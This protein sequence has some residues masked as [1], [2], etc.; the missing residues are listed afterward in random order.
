MS[1]PE[2]HTT[3]PSCNAHIPWSPACINCGEPLPELERETTQTEWINGSL[4]E[5]D[6]DTILQLDPEEKPEGFLACLLLMRLKL[7]RTAAEGS[8]SHEDFMELYTGCRE[9]TQETIQQYESAGAQ[10]GEACI[11]LLDTKEQLEGNQSKIDTGELGIEEFM[12][13][14][15]KLRRTIDKV[16]DNI[17]HL[18]ANQKSLGLGGETEEDLEKLRDIHGGLIHHYQNLPVMTLDNLIPKS[19][20]ETL[21]LD[22]KN[23]LGLLSEIGEE[24]KITESDLAQIEPDTTEEEPQPLDDTPLKEK[25]VLREDAALEKVTKYVKGH[26]DEVKRLLRALRMNDNILILGPPGEGK[27]ETLLRLQDCFGGVYYSCSEETTEREL[28]AGYNPSAFTGENPTHEGLLMR[29]VN[30]VEGSPIAYI[31][32]VMKLRPSAQVILLEAMNNKTFTNPVDGKIYKLPD[33]FCVVAAS[34]LET[35][36]VA[37]PEL[38]FLDRFGKTIMWTT[39]PVENIK[40]LLSRYALP[41]EVFQ[42]T[43][44]IK[45]QV[46]QMNYLAPVSVRNILKFAKEYHEYKRAY[47]D[48]EEL[49]LMAVDRL[50]KIRVMN[51]FGMQEYEEA[52]NGIRSYMW[53]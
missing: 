29:T 10:M 19:Y 18:K 50:L 48:R 49:S 46:N 30:Q 7:L 34:N 42:F 22:L 32:D 40:S 2:D 25:S 23:C 15:T 41:E 26:D 39:T 20:T 38:S 3:C 6:L 33:T 16:Q 17:N 8:I 21:T 14:F 9:R 43:V 45:N 44:W 11:T 1:F 27:T 52:R 36:A 35:T 47:Q 12:E 31:D 37:A 51:I 5:G 53:E 28:V 13:E 4:K 24:F